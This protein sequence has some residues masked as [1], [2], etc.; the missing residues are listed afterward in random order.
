MRGDKDIAAQALERHLKNT[1]ESI[2][3]VLQSA[4]AQEEED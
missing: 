1:L 2:I 4:G 3:A